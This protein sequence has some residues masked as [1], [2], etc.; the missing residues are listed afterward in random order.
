MV[1]WLP[2]Y[3]AT[4]QLEFQI[5]LP[6]CGLQILYNQISLFGFTHRAITFVPRI[7]H[8]HGELGENLGIRLNF[9]TLV[10][11]SS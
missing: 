10:V 3:N 6:S 11:Y 1:F 9:L 7:M 8:V 4:L 5:H 2:Y